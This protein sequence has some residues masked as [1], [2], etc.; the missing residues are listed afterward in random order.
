MKLE[1]VIYSGDNLTW[2]K[3]F[4]DKYIDLIYL[5]P[6][7]FRNRYYEVIFNDG[8]RRVKKNKAALFT[9]VIQKKALE[10]NINL[11]IKKTGI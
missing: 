11:D 10:H 8:E 4:P 9:T 7:F 3:K 5:D 6:P 2:L 1:N